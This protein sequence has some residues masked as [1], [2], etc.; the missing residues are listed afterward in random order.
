MRT[1][2]VATL[3]TVAMLTLAPSAIADPF[4]FS[5]GTPDGQ[6]ATASRL[7]GAFEIETADDFVLTSSTSL[8]SATFTGLIPT[9]SSVLSV[10]IEIYR[11]FPNDSDVGRT[12]G[13]PTF[14]TS[15]V[16]TRVNSPSDVAFD[17]RGSSSGTLSF[18]TSV[19]AA[20]FTAANSVLPGGIHPKPGQTT[21]GNGPFT[22]A[23][24]QFNVDFTTLLSLPAD[25]YFFVPLVELNDANNFL[26]LSAARP[27]VP[28]GTAFPIGTTDLQSWTRDD[29]L[30]PDWLRIG[31]DIV[32]GSPAPTFNAAFSLT[33][34]TTSIPEPGN[35]MIVA[36]SL[37]GL[38]LL[39][40]R[41]RL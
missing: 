40:R 2:T 26:W 12:S 25:H 39:R 3:A 22:G 28:P 5:T 10:A 13:P 17:T 23:E 4:I 29:F 38:L 36:G 34:T 1:P 19:L 15:E 18:S 7:G 37:A 30:D 24:V 6:M 33:G 31:T 21:G 16:P 11:I 20:A 41:V 32:G 9:G 8:S 27:I 14:S 35:L